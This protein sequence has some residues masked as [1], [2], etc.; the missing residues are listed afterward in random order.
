MNKIRIIT[1]VALI[2][3]ASSSKAQETLI[4]RGYLERPNTRASLNLQKKMFCYFKGDYI[5]PEDNS[6]CTFRVDSVMSGSFLNF[7]NE[8]NQPPFNIKIALINECTVLDYRQNYTLQIK[9]F[10][11]TNYYYIDSL[12]QVSPN[13]KYLNKLVEYYKNYRQNIDILTK[14]TLQERNDFLGKLQNYNYISQ[15]TD[16]RYVSYVIPFMAS[17]DTIINHFVLNWD[18]YDKNGRMVGGS[19]VYEEKGLYADNLYNYLDRTLP[20]VLPD[21]TTDSIGWHNWFDSISCSQKFLPVK[22][23]QIEHKTIVQT[24]KNTYYI[25]YFIP[26]VSSRIIYFASDRKYYSL[27]IDTDELTEKPLQQ[28]N[29]PYFENN[30]S[31]QNN[32]IPIYNSFN[33]GIDLSRLDNG[34]FF[35][36][37]NEIIP[38]NLL[39]DVTPSSCKIYPNLIVHS[40]TDFLIF[41]SQN[42]DGYNCLK[43]GK[44]NRKG[45]WIIEPE[46]LYQKPLK[47]YVG[48]T[49]DI[50]AFS[51]YQSNENETTFAF[52]D[53]TFGRNSYSA[54]EKYTDAI[55][56]FKLNSN[57]EVQDSVILT[58]DF[59][60]FDYSFSKTDLL[61]KDSTYLLLALTNSNSNYQLYYRLLNSNLTPKTGF[62][63]LANHLQDYNAVSK[64]IVTAEGFMI[65]WIDNDLSDGILRSVLIDKSGK[66]SE[67][68]NISNQKI[69]NTYNV[70]FDENNVD[71][72]LFNRDEQTLIRKRID[73]KEYRQ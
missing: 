53:R 60:R 33:K 43:V 13:E 36:Q 70:E 16:Y 45:K 22:F 8:V 2:L 27:N 57:L 32:E 73:K 69:D 59:P 39:Y 54:N 29:S 20:F 5:M 15:K 67:I 64:S 42:P 48:D 1:I 12:S 44:I 25:S 49:N 55:I 35:R 11:H 28:S 14:G 68:I 72:Y 34:V 26:D 61:K 31:I 9:R 51:F 19:N 38:L 10:P 17:K 37:D 41:T 58:M 30:Y 40:D 56:A 46:N 52:S 6:F 65:S 23:A 3:L 66:Q 7:K 47:S 18:G 62:I 24:G 63:K 71:I 21:K 4:V 50:R